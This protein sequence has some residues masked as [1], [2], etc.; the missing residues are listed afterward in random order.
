MEQARTISI[1]PE[2]L[3]KRAEKHLKRF[4]ARL[5]EISSQDDSVSVHYTRVSSRRLQ[6][7]LAIIFPKPRTGKQR[8]LI[9]ILRTVR[10]RLGACRSLDVNLDL[11][12]EAINGSP[13][14]AARKA[15]KQLRSHLQKERRKEIQRATRKLSRYRRREFVALSRKCLERIGRELA[16]RNINAALQASL[17]R[18]RQRWHQTLVSA[19]QDRAPER[20]HA[21]RIAGKRLRYR[22]ELFAQF[23]DS[24]A[25]VWVKELKE[26]QQSLG[27]WHDRHVLFQSVAEFVGRPTYLLNQPTIARSLV[28]EMEKEDNQ[29]TAVVESIMKRAGNVSETVEST[30]PSDA[31]DGIRQVAYLPDRRFAQRRS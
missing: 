2:R 1:T 28:N 22:A 3:V 15:W 8:E 18:A 30:W 31:A 25:K 23:G 5:G 9:R 24:R 4:A 13:D 11:I 19:N 14:P 26:L 7:V 10:R 21:L 12:A 16:C 20:L 6:Q 17:E 27:R 29:E